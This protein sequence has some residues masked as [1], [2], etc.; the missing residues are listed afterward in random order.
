[1]KNTTASGSREDER[2]YLIV[3]EDRLAAGLPPLKSEYYGPSWV[4]QRTGARDIT[5][6]IVI[7]PDPGDGSAGSLARQILKLLNDSSLA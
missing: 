3:G 4:I 5:D 1:M 2:R 6:P 7:I